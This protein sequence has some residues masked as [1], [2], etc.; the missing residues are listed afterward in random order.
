L[1]HP[2]SPWGGAQDAAPCASGSRRRL[3][4]SRRPRARRQ[5]A[6]TFQPLVRLL[7]PRRRGHASPGVLPR[8][9][10]PGGRGPTAAAGT[11]SRSRL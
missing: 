7:W 8:G 6:G 11:P 9:R 1:T 3:L 5:R 2:S 4:S 10:R